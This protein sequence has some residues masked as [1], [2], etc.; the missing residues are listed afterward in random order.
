MSDYQHVIKEIPE[1]LRNYITDQN[2]ERYT[3]QD[4]AVWRYIMR[5]NLSFL[6]EH[7]HQAYLEGLAK[8][9]ITLDHIPHI[10]EINECLS[11]IGWKAVIVDGFLP[12][13]VFMEFQFHKILVISAD[14]RTIDHILYTPAPDIV[15]EA[16][17]HAPII[18]GEEYAYYLQKVGEYGMK[19]FSSGLDMEIYEAIRYLSIIKEYPQTKQEDLDLA[20][21]DLSEK[22]A[23]NI[24]PSEMTML[25]RL[26]WWTVEYGLVGTPDNFKLYGAGLLSSVGESKNCLRP[27]VKKIPLSLDCIN[28][29]YD[30]TTE[31]PQLFVNKDWGQ[32]IDVLEQFADTLAFRTGGVKALE[33]A[34]ESEAVSTCIYSSGLQV[35]GKFI[36][37]LKDE[38]NG[39]AYIAT[40]GPTSLSYKYKQ[41][42][43]HGIDY[44]VHGFSSPVG[45][46][47]NFNKP[48]EKCTDNELA[49][50]AVIPDEK[51][52]LDFESG[53]SVKG[54]L[55]KILRKDQKIIV[56]T[57]KDCTVLDRNQQILFDP[58]WGVFDMAVG[59]IIPSV[60]F[61]TADKEKHNV[62]PPKSEKKAIPITYSQND[63]K[64]H[65]LYEDIWLMQ[66]TGRFTSGR[67]M[68]IYT[69]LKQHPDNWLVRLELLQVAKNSGN[70]IFVTQMIE[71]D[72][73]RLSQ[74]SEEK[75]EIIE[76]GLKLLN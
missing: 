58:S 33:K 35:S 73:S 55:K 30:I 13:A 19:A 42:D 24:N 8:T 48:L 56:M 53:I 59:E 37:I 23:R 52:K 45:K 43:G 9:G 69:N 6:K 40:S 38:N 67:I 61:G 7:A 68:E 25:S 16:A 21:K 36:K 17:G 39:P 27:Q 70:N 74:Q 41:L 62:Y 50:K 64:L 66:E 20:E 54:V 14:I 29:N 4:H 2:Y 76:S 71:N 1:H 49:E 63:K 60:F 72:L 47:K 3:P 28:Y 51:V 31:Q 22:I 11:K 5:R 34:I 26:H 57:F 32:L 46:L 75:K 10:D 65:Q 15:H 18:A 12:P 44:H